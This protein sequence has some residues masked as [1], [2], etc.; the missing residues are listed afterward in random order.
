MYDLPDQQPIRDER[1]DVTLLF[2]DLRRCT[3]LAASLG[4]EPLFCELLAH[5]MDCLTEAVMEHDGFVI[6][7]YGD[8]LASMWNAPAMQPAHA[9]K[10]CRAALLMLDKLTSVAAEW[11]RLIQSDLRLGIGVH[12]GQVQVGNSGSTHRVKY[13]ARGPN[14]HLAS[15]VEAATKELHIPFLA[16]AATAN[17]LPD[18]LVAH[19]VCRAQLLGL[20]EAVDLFAVS[21]VEAAAVDHGEWQ[22]YNE[23]L[24]HFEMG[25][26]QRASDALE[27]ID[28]SDAEVPTQFLRDRIHIELSRNLR[29]RSTDMPTASPGG[30]IAINTK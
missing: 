27:S 9:E 26:M 16:T 1:R 15:R 2:A 28:R 14:V 25:Q 30:V 11:R 29:R 13:G 10:A 3:D 20:R 23:A 8:G 17:C 21:S 6:D 22:K 12:T 19:R 24:R 4:T 18:S 5:V 7:Y